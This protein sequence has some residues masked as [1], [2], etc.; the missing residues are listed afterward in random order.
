MGD[1]A[2]LDERCAQARETFDAASLIPLRTVAELI[3]RVT[4]EN[5]SQRFILEMIPADPE[6]GMDVYEVDWDSESRKPV[7]RGN[8][9]VS[10]AT[11]YNYYLKYFAYLDFPYVGDCDL[12][13]PETMPEVTEKVRIVFPY[14]NRHYFNENC[15]YKYTTAL[16]TK[17]EWTHRLDWMAM[18]G[19]KW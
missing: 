5:S 17:K 7:L 8:D 14:E 10:L 13:L 12:V 2:K 3:D 6:T 11:A 18:N 16:Y 19:F 9:A 15:E 4:G 1:L